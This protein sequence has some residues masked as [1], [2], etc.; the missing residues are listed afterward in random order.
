[1]KKMQATQMVA[2]G[3][4]HVKPGEIYYVAEIKGSGTKGNNNYRLCRTKSRQSVCATVG[5][6]FVDAMVELPMS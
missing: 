5:K 1:M 6:S 4:W 3:G 2:M